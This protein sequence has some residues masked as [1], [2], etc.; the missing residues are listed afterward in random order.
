VGTKTLK[1]G[2]D[3]TVAYKNNTNVGTATVTVTGK[4]SYTGTKSATFKI[5]QAANTAKAA[6]TTVSKTIKVATA[7]RAAQKVT[8]P[9]VTS[10]FGKAVWKVSTKDKKK[11]LTLKSGKVVVKKGAK[12]GTYYIKLKATVAATKNYKSATTKVVTVKV[13]VK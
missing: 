12:K 4:G 6:K 7:K 3:Y 8:L 11:V 13:V 5:T 9:K 2:T 1:A 10:K